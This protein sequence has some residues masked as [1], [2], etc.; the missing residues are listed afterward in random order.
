MKTIKNNYKKF[1][2]LTMRK[3]NKMK[4]LK[5][6]SK[7]FRKL[8]MRKNNKM[9]TLKVGGS[10]TEADTSLENLREGIKLKKKN[11]AF[12]RKTWNDI[13]L[14][15]CGDNLY[16]YKEKYPLKDLNVNH[17]VDSA[18]QIDLTINTKKLILQATTGK[19]AQNIK[20]HLKTLAN[21]A[22][23]KAEKEKDKAEHDLLDAQLAAENTKYTAFDD[24]F[25]VNQNNH[26]QQFNNAF[27]HNQD[28]VSKVLEEFGFKDQ[29][30][31]Y[32]EYVK[33]RNSEIDDSN[34]EGT[35]NDSEDS[36]DE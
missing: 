19:E 29:A 14:H 32:A 24:E 2:K 18:D 30:D 26:D 28:E 9:K 6:N 16:I 1:R 34:A 13:Y 33:K 25:R 10:D 7:K 23:K 11:S 3:K 20:K 15:A 21:E 5:D 22:K 12:A 27:E 36:E 8:T 35:G 17:E 31:K 4:T